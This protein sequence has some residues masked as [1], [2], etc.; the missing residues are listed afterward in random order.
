[1]HCLASC[2]EKQIS[3]LWK[4][5]QELPSTPQLRSTSNFLGR[6]KPD[7]RPSLAKGRKRQLREPLLLRRLR[8]QP[9]SSQAKL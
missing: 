9:N 1:M 7:R 5:K 6:I 4:T 3:S 2:D 8:K